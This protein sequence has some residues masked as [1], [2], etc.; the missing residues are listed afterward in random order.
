MYKLSVTLLTIS[1]VIIA[2]SCVTVEPLDPELP[3]SIEI[4]N[5]PEENIGWYSITSV[6][7]ALEQS[8]EDN[9][10]LNQTIM[11]NV[12]SGILKYKNG[13]E[14]KVK[15]IQKHKRYLVILVMVQE[16]QASVTK[17]SG[18]FLIKSGT[19]FLD[20]NKDFYDTAIEAIRRYVK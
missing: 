14:F 9:P 13:T 19:I 18:Q 5:I 7:I 1:M 11:P 4:I 16:G 20:Y 3:M 15:N 8:S 12:L 6:Y 10:R 2:M 17:Y